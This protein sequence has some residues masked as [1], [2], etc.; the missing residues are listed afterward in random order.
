MGDSTVS[1]TFPFGSLHAK[2]SRSCCPT[3]CN[4]DIIPEHT[5]NFSKIFSGL[6]IYT[7]NRCEHWEVSPAIS[8]TCLYFVGETCSQ[9]PCLA[10]GPILE[11]SGTHEVIVHPH[12]Q[13]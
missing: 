4:V 5:E 11:M 10:L 2:S 7:V 12:R 3:A 9:L 13:S 1:D 8:H 6:I